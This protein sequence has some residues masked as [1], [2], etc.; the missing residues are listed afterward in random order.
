M[1]QLSQCVLCK[2]EEDFEMFREAQ[3]P[4]GW[5]PPLDE[6]QEAEHL[7][8]S[9]AS[10][11][12][13]Q[14]VLVPE[15]PEYEA[16]GVPPD[17]MEESAMLVQGTEPSSG[18][19]G[20]QGAGGVSLGAMEGAVSAQGAESSTRSLGEQ[21]VAPPQEEAAAQAP[22]EEVPSRL[23]AT[24]VAFLLQ[25]YRS[26][27]PTTKAEILSRLFPGQQQ[28]FPTVFAKACE[29]MQVVFG[30][31]VREAD[32]QAQSYDLAIA[33]GL[34]YDGML[35]PEQSVPKTGLLLMVLGLILLHGDCAPE[36][37]VWEALAMMGI[38]ACGDH[39]LFGD[40]WELLTQEWVL[41]QY[42]V[43][44]HV[45]GSWP[46][47]YHFHWGPRAHHEVCKLRLLLWLKVSSTEPT[48]FLYP[49][50]SYS[51]EE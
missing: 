22:L 17:G 16:G 23:V 43:Y 49:Y 37:A 38:Y 33:L 28:L 25:K 35:G 48:S 20:E 8:S 9:S 41:E 12:L 2:L 39:F 47:H 36:E 29:C 7:S 24:V 10:S 5:Q 26:R 30:I 3:G 18:I 21:G 34:S 50:Q 51:E 32:P 19:P 42:L 44:Q 11:S 46:A 6:H 13:P 15:A 45:P 1:F 40:P 31:E 27:E 14:S 4:Q